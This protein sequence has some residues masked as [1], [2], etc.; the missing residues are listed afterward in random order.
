MARAQVVVM[1]LQTKECQGLL[2]PLEAGKEH[3]RI[4]PEFQREQGPADT[5]VLDV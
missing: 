2:A 5:L 3:E 1:Q 4:Y